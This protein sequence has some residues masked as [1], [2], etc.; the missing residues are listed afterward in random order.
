MSKIEDEFT[1]S[2]AQIA[3]RFKHVTGI[4]MH[5]TNVGQAAK[6]LHLDYIEVVPDDPTFNPAW[7]VK[8]KL[9]AE[10]DVPAIFRVLEEKA[11]GLAQY[12]PQMMLV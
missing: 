5:P 12:N 11:C 9:Y 7:K 2:A 8:R 1:L 6:S 10:R 4:E 3:Q